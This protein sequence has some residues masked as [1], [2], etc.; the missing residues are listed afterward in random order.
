MSAP[1][2]SLLDS[3]QTLQ[4]SYDEET[5]SLRTKTDANESSVEVFQLD[6]ESL[7]ANAHLMVNGEPVSD[8]NPIPTTATISLAS[9]LTVV[10]DN[11]SELQTTANLAV[12]NAPVSEANPVPILLDQDSKDILT[13]IDSKLPNLGPQVS[14]NSLSVTLATDQS[15]I[16]TLL[17]GTDNG[18][19]TGNKFLYVNNIKN[20]ILATDD[21]DQEIIYEDF[22]T[23]NQ[24][25]T[26]I[27][28]TSDRFPGVTAKK[29][30]TYVLESGRYKRTNI[31]WSIE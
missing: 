18:L 14:N 31:T 30:L 10:Q 12:D 17:A 26:E 1:K 22:G 19:I 23:K 9:E 29:T 7:Q 27:N 13:T 28:Y 3:G 25:I 6:P 11:A 8:T 5:G 21:R 24:R 20:Q 4:G 2:P 15:E 16:K